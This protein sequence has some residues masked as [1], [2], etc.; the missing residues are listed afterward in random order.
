MEPIGGS[1]PELHKVKG[2][3]GQ[4]GQERGAS[5]ER[6]VSGKVTSLWEAAGGYEVFTS[7]GLPREFQTVWLRSHSWKGLTLQSG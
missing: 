2:V 5:K 4:K 1:S 7:P 3:Y 6:I